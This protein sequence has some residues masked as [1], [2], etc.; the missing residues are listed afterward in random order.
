MSQEFILKIHIS[1]VEIYGPRHS[2]TLQSN[3]VSFQI[4]AKICIMGDVCMF[5]CP[6]KL[7]TE[8]DEICY[9]G[10][11]MQSC[12]L[13][14][15]FFHIGPLKAKLKSDVPSPVSGSS[16]QLASWTARP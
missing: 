11:Y 15:I 8:C 10:V 7:L 9:C 4:L 3:T 12:K 6:K 1:K 14:L 16:N 2:E 13:Y 5:H